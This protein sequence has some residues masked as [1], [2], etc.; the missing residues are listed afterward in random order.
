MIII[1]NSTATKMCVAVFVSLQAEKADNWRNG[2][3]IYH[4]VM[5][6]REE[7]C[8]ALQEGSPRRDY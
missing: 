8:R 7:S 1:Y 3:A 5:I 2:D 6:A 4:R